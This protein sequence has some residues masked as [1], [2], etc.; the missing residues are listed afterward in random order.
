MSNILRRDEN[1]EIEHIEETN[2]IN[3]MQQ[4]QLN[5]LRKACINDIDI[6]DQIKILLKNTDA[7]IAEI[8]D[9]T[10]DDM[11]TAY[12]YA[13]TNYQLFVEKNSAIYT[14]LCDTFDNRLAD[15]KIYTSLKD[16]LEPSN[17]KEAV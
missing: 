4:R 2:K 8:S 15:E 10:Y 13:K 9:I 5:E 14:V 7:N 12:K 6:F 3:D 11:M 1:F 17:N 16:I